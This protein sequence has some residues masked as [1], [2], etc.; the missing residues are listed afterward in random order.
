MASLAPD[1][2][3]VIAEVNST[4]QGGNKGAWYKEMLTKEIPYNFPLVK[5]VVIYNEDRTKQEKVN[6]KVDVNKESLEAFK[7][8]VKSSFYN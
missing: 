2:P 6:W 4:D 7:S 5:A 3:M 8:S 1:K